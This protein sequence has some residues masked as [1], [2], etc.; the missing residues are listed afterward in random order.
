MA[1][2]CMSL[3]ASCVL[4][5]NNTQVQ[6]TIVCKPLYRCACAIFSEEDG[7]LTKFAS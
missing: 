5:V 2:S 7:F 1:A 3:S 4:F 6:A